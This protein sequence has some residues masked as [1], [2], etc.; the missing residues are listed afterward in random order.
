MRCILDTGAPLALN[1]SKD[2]V[3]PNNVLCKGAAL[4]YVKQVEGLKEG[5]REKNGWKAQRGVD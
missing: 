3:S 2:K 1:H 5:K 4:K